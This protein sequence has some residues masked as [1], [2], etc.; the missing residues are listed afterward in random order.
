MGDLWYTI[1]LVALFYPSTSNSITNILSACAATKGIERVNAMGSSEP[2][3]AVSTEAKPVHPVGQPISASTNSGFKVR[4]TSEVSFPAIGVTRTW[5]P[6][7]PLTGVFANPIVAISDSQ[8]RSKRPGQTG[9][10][11]IGVAVGFLVGCLALAILYFLLQITMEIFDVSRVRFRAPIA[12]FILPFIT[13]FFGFKVGPDLFLL[14][15]EMPGDAGPWT[16]LLLAKSV[17]W[18]VVVLAYVLIFD[19]FGHFIL[20]DEWLFVAKVVLFPIG[21]IWCG[22]WLFTKFVFRK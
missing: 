17:F 9:H 1:R 8:K 2:A 4:R 15:Q 16:R 22:A 5:R 20:D 6:S 19:P 18:A 14:V 21:V 3:R 12:I 7:R 13:A 10:R 11:L